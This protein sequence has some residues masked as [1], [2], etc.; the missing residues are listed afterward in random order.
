MSAV[1]Y[2]NTKMSFCYS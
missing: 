1:M 2:M